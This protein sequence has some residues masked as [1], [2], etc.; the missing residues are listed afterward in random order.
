[1]LKNPGTWSRN[2]RRAQ[3]FSKLFAR[4]AFSCSLH[5]IIFSLEKAFV[6]ADISAASRAESKQ[7]WKVTLNFQWP[8]PNCTSLTRKF[9]S[10]VC[11]R[12]YNLRSYRA[13]TLEKGEG[14]ERSF[15]PANEGNSRLS[16]SSLRNETYKANLVI[17]PLAGGIFLNKSPQK[18]DEKDRSLFLIGSRESA[19]SFSFPLFIHSTPSLVPHMPRT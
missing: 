10:K 5:P 3:C 17:S 4:W 6:V 7:V 19:T 14:E 18:T 12:E 16:T 13:R 8:N 1:M 11:V 15:F 9:C 2:K